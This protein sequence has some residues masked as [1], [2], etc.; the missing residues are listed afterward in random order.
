M[1]F[2][3]YIILKRVS[4][5]RDYFEKTFIY[6]KICNPKILQKYHW[7]RES[8]EGVL[9]HDFF[10]HFFFFSLITNDK[11]VD[12]HFTLFLTDK[13]TKKKNKTY[14]GVTLKTP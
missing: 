10:F 1:I 9:C 13:K 14:E 5:Y 8:E 11:F 6:N 7:L 3:D 4:N 2:L 12:F